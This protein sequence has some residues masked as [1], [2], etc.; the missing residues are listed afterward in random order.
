[1]TAA[2]GHQ[3]F[4]QALEAIESMEQEG[5][6]PAR[7]DSTKL[8]RL[9]PIMD[10]RFQKGVHLLGAVD[11]HMDDVFLRE[12]HG[13]V[14]AVIAGEHAVVFQSKSCRVEK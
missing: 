1:M 3:R 11:L 12:L 6:E 13:K 8:Q 9:Q 2:Q 14:F 10:I 7:V 4:Q 5:G